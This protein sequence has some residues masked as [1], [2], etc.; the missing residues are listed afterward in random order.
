M[1]EEEILLDTRTEIA[2][3]FGVDVERVRV[4][5]RYT[6]GTANPTPEPDLVV[7]GRPMWARSRRDEWRSWYAARPGR[8]GRPKGSGKQRAAGPELDSRAAR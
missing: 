2:A 8:T 5:Q 6:R 1:G 3:L 4:W 7:S